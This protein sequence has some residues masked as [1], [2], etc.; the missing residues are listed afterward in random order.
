MPCCSFSID[1]C[2][3]SFSCYFIIVANSPSLMIICSFFSRFYTSSYSSFCSN[4]AIWA[5]LEI[6]VFSSGGIDM[7]IF[8]Y[9]SWGELIYHWFVTDLLQS[10]FD[11]FFT[12]SFEELSSLCCNNAESITP[13][14]VAGQHF[15]IYLALTLTLKMVRNVNVN[16][17][18]DLCLTLS[19][20]CFTLS[21]EIVP[22]L[23]IAKSQAL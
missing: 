14:S 7:E 3:S 10:I 16:V 1:F 5:S 22:W 18:L 23:T 2:V 8:A 11:L 19:C 13:L 12:V 4:K 17:N 6:S 20:D 21:C 9:H 15:S